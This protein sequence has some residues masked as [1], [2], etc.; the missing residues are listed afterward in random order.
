MYKLYKVTTLFLN[1]KTKYTLFSIKNEKI[2][3]EKNY[4]LLPVPYSLLLAPYSLLPTP[5]SL[6]PIPCSLPSVLLQL[7]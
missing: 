5:Y 4:P 1:N 7:S 6:L 3:L 2:Y